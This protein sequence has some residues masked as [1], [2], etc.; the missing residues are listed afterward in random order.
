[1]L[2]YPQMEVLVSVLYHCNSLTTIN[3]SSDESHM[4]NLSSSEVAF[5]KKIITTIKKLHSIIHTNIKLH[6]GNTHEI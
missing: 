6:H 2:F 5:L 4:I 1:M 3:H